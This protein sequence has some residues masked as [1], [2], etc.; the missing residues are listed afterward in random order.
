[1]LLAASN[2]S[3]YERMAGEQAH[4]I[5]AKYAWRAA[6]ARDILNRYGVEVDA[7]INGVF[8]PA[9]QHAGLHTKHY[10]DSVNDLLRQAGSQSD[11]AAILAQIRQQLLSGDMIK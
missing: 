10:Y 3:S 7:A 8:L 11:V 9:V 1:M 6:L 4:H 5:V 2:R